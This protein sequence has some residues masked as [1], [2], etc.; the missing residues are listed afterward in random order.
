[1]HSDIHLFSGLGVGHG[2]QELHVP[3]LVPPDDAGA[4]VQGGD[5]PSVDEGPESFG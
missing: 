4:P 2:L 5:G 1:M 3:L